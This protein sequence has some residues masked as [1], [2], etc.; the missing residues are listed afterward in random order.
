MRHL[1]LGLSLAMLLAGCQMAPYSGETQ[2]DESIEIS[3]VNRGTDRTDSAEADPPPSDR[4]RVARQVDFPEDQYAALE[5]S[6][7]AAL[8]GRLTL[9]TASGTAVGAGETISVAPITTYSAE[10]AEQALAGRAVER[11]DPRA[12]AYTHTTRTD[13]N[14]YFTLRGLPSGDFYVSG[15][16][17]NPASGQRQ[18]VIH[19]ISLGKGQHREIDLSR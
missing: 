9:D 1:F 8:S 2:R 15:S 13:G 4:G 6:G 12:R 19:E 5:K 3:D 16:L 11:A 17:V 7:S 18:V 14:G 10:A